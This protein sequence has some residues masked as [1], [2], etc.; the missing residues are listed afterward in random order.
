M[1]RR[2]PAG[3]KEQNLQFVTIDPSSD[4]GSSD[5]R[6]IVRSH[7]GGWIWRQLREN[8]DNPQL[9]PEEE[10]EEDELSADPSVRMESQGRHRSTSQTGKPTSAVAEAL[11][12]FTPEIVQRAG[13]GGRPMLM[14][15]STVSSEKLDPFQSYI[16]T[17]PLPSG[18]VSNSNKYCKTPP[19]HSPHRHLLTCS[20]RL[21]GAMARPHAKILLNRGRSSRRY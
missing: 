10:Q 8:Q 5:I 7:A 6:R 17:S 16:S 14:P 18:L 19:K 12:E 20:L 11:R 9:D 1:S 21:I 13:N 4:R 15:L 3:N 2:A